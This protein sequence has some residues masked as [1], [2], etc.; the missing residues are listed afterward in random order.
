MK[1]QCPF[2]QPIKKGSALNGREPHAS[3]SWLPGI[4][5]SPYQ[6]CKMF[7]QLT[8]T[9]RKFQAQDIGHLGGPASL[10]APNSLPSIL[11][12]HSCPTICARALPIHVRQRK[13]LGL[14]YVLKWDSQKQ[15]LFLTSLTN[16]TPP[17]PPKANKTSPK[18][19]IYSTHS[20][21]T[22]SG[23]TPRLVSRPP[24]PRRAHT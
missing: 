10:S 20:A 17:H 2:I 6:E 7:E 22:M 4:C 19:P 14:G 18:T 16:P 11:P 24:A 5:S 3:Q 12:A 15:R 21:G 13:I 9:L 8:E 1:N 23:G